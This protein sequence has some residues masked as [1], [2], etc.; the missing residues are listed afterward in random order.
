MTHFATF[1]GGLDS[2]A[3]L[4]LL[5][6]RHDPSSVVAVSFDYGQRHEVELRAAAQITSHL[7]V[8]HRVLNLRGLLSGS[9]LTGSGAIPEGRYDSTTMASTVVN[10]RNLL[11]ASAV[12]A[13]TAPGDTI[14]FGVHA[15]DHHVYPDC[16]PEFVDALAAVAA[17]YEVAV[18][19]PWVHMTKD[20][21]VSQGRALG[22]PLH[23]TWS[24]YNGTP[25]QHCGR[26]GT[27]VERAEA[28]H[29]AG[30]PDPTD[31]ADPHYWSTLRSTA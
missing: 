3:L 14:A 23:L 27:C 16:R 28:F 2:T 29:L 22:A 25:P 12:I 20:E 1:S 11:F 19:A 24:C 4:A 6:D 15:G 30:V 31:Y 26:C 18:E 8:E 9:S 13:Q 5:V 7:G 21:I 17:T 10:G